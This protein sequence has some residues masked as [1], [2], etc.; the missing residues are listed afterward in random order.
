MLLDLR[1]FGYIRELKNDLSVEMTRK[2]QLARL[3][4]IRKGSAIGSR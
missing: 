2:F 1:G 4:I 3:I